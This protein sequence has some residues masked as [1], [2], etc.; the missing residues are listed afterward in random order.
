MDLQHIKTLIF[1]FGGVLIDLDRQRCIDSFVKLGFSDVESLLD[2]CHQHDFFL[3]H[4]KGLLNDGEFRAEIRRRI[5]H[6]VT[7][8][9][10]DQA[11]NR[12]LIGVPAYKLDFLSQLR[13]RYT[14]YM[15]SNTNGIHWHWALEHVFNE[16]GHRIEDLFDRIFLSFEMKMVKP[17]VEI[18][19][20]V[21]DETG[22]NPSETLFLDDAEVNCRTARSLGIH[23]YTPQPHEDWRHLFNREETCS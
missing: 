23:T 7:D 21:M 5:S 19:R 12:F 16:E 14:L 4:E 3:Q 20:R 2:I 17:D 1:D 6:P 18:F 22:L 15:L 13:K 9:Q 8:V 10:I 11:W